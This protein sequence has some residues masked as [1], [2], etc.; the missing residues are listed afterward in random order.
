M[1]LWNGTRS[2]KGGVLTEYFEGIDLVAAIVER[3]R[4][5]YDSDEEC[6]H[7]NGGHKLRDCSQQL[8]DRLWT[9]AGSNPEIDSLDISLECMR[10]IRG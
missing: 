8:I 5:D 9:F 3:A 1:L 7:V 6:Q 10:L 4:M 2:F